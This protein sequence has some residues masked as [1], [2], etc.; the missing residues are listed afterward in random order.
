MQSYEI[1]N[2]IVCSVVFVTLTALLTTLIVWIIKLTLRAIEGGLE[3]EK[4]K[5]ECTKEKKKESPIIVA[6]DKVFPIFVCVILGV[7]LC[8]SLYSRFTQNEKVD[9]IPTIK[10]VETGSMESKHKENTYLF[11][12]N[13]NDQ[14]QTF[15]LIV[16]HK[17]PNEEDLK[18]YDIVVYEVNGY[19]IVHRIVGIEEPNERHPNE[20]WFVLRGDANKM[21]DDFPVTYSQ[22]KSVYRGERIPFVGSFVFFMQSPAGI[23]CFLLVIFA[24]IA[25]PIA[26]K[27]IEKAKQ[28]RYALVLAKE[29]EEQEQKARKEREKEAREK[30][31]ASTKDST[32]DFGN[33]ERKTFKEKLATLP[34]ERLDWYDQ[35]VYVLNQLPKIRKIEAK[36]HEAYRM[37]NKS[38]TK[39]TIRGKSIYAYLAVDAN[40]YKSVQ[41]GFKDVSEIKSHGQLISLCKITSERKL[42]TVKKILASYGEN[43]RI[44]MPLKDFAD[45]KKGKRLTFKQKVA[46]LLDERKDWLKQ[47]VSELS[48]LPKITKRE[49]KNGLTFKKGLSPV[50]KIL[51]KGKSIYVYL[52]VDP[53]Q[54]TL[55]KYGIVDVSAIKSH[56]NYPAQCK[57]TSERKLKYVKEIIKS[58]KA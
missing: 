34:Q 53:S 37:G 5:A 47:I 41:H 24:V 35:L 15:D 30:E 32:L 52:A 18:M 12:N 43:I 56:S 40:Q 6:I 28:A 17:L 20:R 13:L 14:I 11:D 48:Q 21:A 57:I 4:I 31:E 50:A 16:L 3:D 22:M 44:D 26:E 23:L 27:K 33:R 19:H 45:F 49:S 46:R 51:I 9:V 54:Y 25:T 39:L 36:Y 8:F 10:F 38:I 42:K 7:T 55:A 58:F 2:L 1:Y 29:K